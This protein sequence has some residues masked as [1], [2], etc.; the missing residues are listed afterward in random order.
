M[1]QARGPRRK[2]A[3]GGKKYRETSRDSSRH[4]VHA[5]VDVQRFTRQPPRI[6]SRE[7][8]A[9]ESDVHDVDQ[10]AKRRSLRRLGEQKV[11]ILEA[12]CRARLERSRRN[13]V[14]T[15]ALPAE[16]VGEIAA[17]RLERRL[18]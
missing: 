17:A 10:L 16:L 11:E 4:D 13:G 3:A 2:H 6:G 18:Q 12:G 8:R 7:K 5:A 15:N 14:D 1:R 9:S